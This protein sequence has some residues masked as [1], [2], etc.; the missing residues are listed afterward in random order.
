LLFAFI[1]YGDP[2]SKA[3]SNP[4]FLQLF[5]ALTQACQKVGDEIRFFDEQL[6]IEA[7]LR[8]RRYRQ[9]HG[10]IGIFPHRH[11]TALPI[12]K[13]LQGLTPC[14]NIAIRSDAV[15]SWY[16]GTD[17]GVGAR[18]LVENLL[19]RGHRKMGFVATHGEPYVLERYQGWR[20]AMEGHGLPINP[21]W[22]WGIDASRG[23]FTRDLLDRF[24]DPRVDLENDVARRASRHLISLPTKPEAL[25]FSHTRTAVAFFFV[26]RESL[27]D[28]PGDIALCGFD[29]THRRDL[30]LTTVQHDIAEI[31]RSAVAILKRRISGKS[32]SPREI[33]V[34]PRLNLQRLSLKCS[35]SSH[36]DVRFGALVRSYVV[37]NF[38][39]PDSL[40]QMHDV[41]G[42]SRAYFVKRCR[43][44]LGRSLPQLIEEQRLNI[45]A[46]SLGHGKQSTTEIAFSVG[47]NHYQ[48]FL[49][50][51]KIRYGVS[52]RQFRGS[53][54]GERP[55]RSSD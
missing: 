39:A 25:V 29:D 45:A 27:K 44:I 10:L 24:H 42:L 36:D 49:R 11:Q 19:S 5:A 15:G 7:F 46:E 6:P 40:R 20:H 18:L 26:A 3:L 31:G 8:S 2:F 38:D 35:P 37:N 9:Y 55:K 17:E 33:L 21:D 13:R 41:F 54:A 12:W 22:I 16:A 47:F 14:V 4:F 50:R 43:R 51:F 48:H 53:L 23:R 34:V 30:P 28:W 52:P 32:R 1:T